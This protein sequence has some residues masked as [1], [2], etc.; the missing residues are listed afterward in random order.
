MPPLTTA[1]LAVHDA[2]DVPDACEAAGCDCGIDVSDVRLP[3]LEQLTACPSGHIAGGA[4]V[5]FLASIDPADLLTDT[6]VL[7]LALAWDR[8]T[9]WT[10]ARGVRAVAEFARRPERVGIED[11]LVSRARR[12]RVGAVGR[13]SPESEI[14]AVLALSPS[15]ALDRVALATW[16]CGRFPSSLRSLESGRIDLVR[17]RGLLAEVGPC[18]DG[19]AQAVEAAVL[20][21]GAEASAGRFRAQARRTVVRLDPE[22]AAL[23]ARQQRTDSFVRCRPAS[24]DV[25]WLEAHLPAEQALLVRSVLDAAATS[26]RGRSGEQRTLDQLRAAALVAPFRAA[27]AC[28]ALTTPDGLLPLA[29]VGG[30]T[31]ALTLVHHADGTDELVGHGPICAL[32]AGEIASMAGVG[33]WPVVRIVRRDPGG[34]AARTAQWPVEELYRPSAALARVV[35]DR[36]RGCRFPGCS[37]SAAGT[38]LDHTEPWPAGPT[39]PSNLASSEYD[40]R[41]CCQPGPRTEQARGRARRRRA[42]YLN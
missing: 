19:P 8:A 20:A 15:A 36:D 4:L 29:T 34:D 38:D 12:R 16:A 23:R 31:P 37:A 26:L 30:R 25:A 6:E 39:H 13:W 28:G 14:G 3:G 24:D 33:R 5:P 35:R 2:R 41:L 9:S 17:L 42:L 11:P 27:I 7:D 32:A 22:G 21:G 40:P 18:D 1:S 10:Q